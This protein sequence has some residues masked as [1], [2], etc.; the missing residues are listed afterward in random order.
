MSSGIKTSPNDPQPSRIARWLRE[1]L[2]HFLLIGAALFVAYSALNP[3]SF[4]QT[5]LNRIELTTDD[6]KLMEVGWVS[7]WKRPPTP[8]EMERLI[9]SRVREEV[10]YREALAMGLDQNDTIVKRRM[11]QKMEFLA[12]DLS[13]LREPE[14]AELEAWFKQNSNRFARPPRATFRHIYFSPDRRGERAQADAAEILAQLRS[15]SSELPEAA[16]RG[17]PFMF[18]DAYADRTPDQ[19][20]NVFGLKFT[21]AL[22][23]LAPGKWQGPVESGLGWH[24]VLVQQ[25]APGR[26]P[27]FAEVEPEARDAWVMDQRA[28]FKSKAYDMMRA[29][30][31]VVLPTDYRVSSSEAGALSATETP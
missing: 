28:E 31:E 24:L 14:R 8:Q 16:S 15:T 9:E 12:E 17:D 18:Q 2:L 26:V 3:G 23:K 29:G 21:E 6:L 11:A 5:D 13:D 4:E 27:D 30:Y 1:P 10:L 7:Q 22:F 19:V 20:A 25:I